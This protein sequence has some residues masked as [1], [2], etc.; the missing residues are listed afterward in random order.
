MA[1]PNLIRENKVRL[2]CL[3]RAEYKQCAFWA[4]SLTK[5]AHAAILTTVFD[6]LPKCWPVAGLDHLRSGVNNHATTGGRALFRR[7]QAAH[8]RLN[9]RGIWAG[10]SLEGAD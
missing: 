8:P 1:R 2:V 3:E 4:M 5:K 6:I 9:R 7:R 10:E